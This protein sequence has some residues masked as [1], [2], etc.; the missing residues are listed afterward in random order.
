MRLIGIGLLAFLLAG[1]ALLLARSEMVGQTWRAVRTLTE[2]PQ[3]RF[4]T[5]MAAEAQRGAAQAIIRRAGP[6]APLILSGLPAYQGAVFHMPI[7]ARPTSGYLQIDATS[8]V[9]DGVEGVLRISIDNTRRAEVLLHPGEA[10]RAVRIEL[11]AA[12]IARAQL[13]VSFSLLGTGSDAVCTAD[14]AVEAVVEIETT[15]ALYLSLDAPLETPRDR[16]ATW[17]NQLRLLWDGQAQGL[18]RAVEARRAGLQVLFVS[19]TGLSAA[20]VDAVL[21]DL[22]ATPAPMQPE[23]AWSEALADG[24]G[25]HGL[26]RFHGST[27][28][29]LRYDLAR[30]QRPNLPGVLELSMAIPRHPMGADWQLTVTHDDRLLAHFTGDADQ[31]HLQER[32]AIPRRAG[33]RHVIEITLTSTFQPTG[34][35]NDGPEVLAEILPETRII[36]ATDMANNPVALLRNGLARGA[37]IAVAV[38]GNLNTAEAD[39]ATDLLQAVLPSQP[40]AIASDA[41]P[42]VGVL[43]RGARLSDDP[44]AGLWLMFRDSE[45]DLVTVPAADYAGRTLTAVSLLVDLSGGAS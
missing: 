45:G 29:R 34:T 16:M 42:I 30:A 2:G 19:E 39:V 11:T 4:E 17:G 7:D 18:L 21:A 10:A 27:T 31:T 15:S 36:P 8:Q 32:I 33:L 6:A 20:D 44:E 1:L 43:P 40:L 9:L 24:G 38:A 25:L 3:L 14:H 37:A 28:W 35:C 5:P 12:D 41:A 23:F 13:V 26:R 22:R